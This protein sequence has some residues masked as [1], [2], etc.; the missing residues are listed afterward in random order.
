MSYA[1][2]MMFMG[3]FVA[4]PDALDAI[5]RDDAAVAATR[6][7]ALLDATTGAVTPAAP[8]R[9]AF[10]STGKPGRALRVPV[11]AAAALIIPAVTACR[12]CA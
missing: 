1:T 5:A 12:L 3:G 10:A 6:G 7:N 2:E 9:G 4:T 11:S 8:T